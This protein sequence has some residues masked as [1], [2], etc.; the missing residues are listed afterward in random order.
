[1]ADAILHYSQNDYYN[2]QSLC[3]G[4]DAKPTYPRGVPQRM[5]E[6]VTCPECIEIDKSLPA[7]KASLM[8]VAAEAAQKAIAHQALRDAQCAYKDCHALWTVE[9]RDRHYNIY[10]FCAVHDDLVFPKIGPEQ[11][12]IIR[13]T[14]A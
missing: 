11:P 4:G 5:R 13:T 3:R 7:P 8:E 9:R 2:G 6:E 14:E 1:M 10:R 12:P